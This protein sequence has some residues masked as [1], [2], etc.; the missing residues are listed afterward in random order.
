MK[1]LIVICLSVTPVVSTDRIFGKVQKRKQSFIGKVHNLKIKE[2][3]TGC[4][5]KPGGGTLNS[6]IVIH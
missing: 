4:L 3:E 6:Q 1:N 5:G 2:K